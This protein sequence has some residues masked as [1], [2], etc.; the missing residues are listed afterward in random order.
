MYGTLEGVPSS[1]RVCHHTSV[2][3]PG[4]VFQPCPR[5]IVQLNEST[6]PLRR[7]VD[8]TASTSDVFCRLFGTTITTVTCRQSPAQHVCAKSTDPI[9]SLFSRV[10]VRRDRPTPCPLF[11]GVGMYLCSL[12]VVDAHDSAHR[13][14]VQCFT[15]SCGGTDGTSW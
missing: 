15:V 7:T 5:D 4:T 13:V 8:G 6:D 10:Q 12:V 3:R 1:S 9:R 2:K 14:C 11:D